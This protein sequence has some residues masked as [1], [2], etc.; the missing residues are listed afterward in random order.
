[1]FSRSLPTDTVKKSL[2]VTLIS[3]FV[4]ICAV[5]LLLATQTGAFTDIAFEAVSALGTAGLTRSYTTSLNTFG[6][7]I[8]MIC[9]YLGRVG[10]ISL[11]IALSGKRREEYLIL[12]EEDIRVG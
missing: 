7:I 4:M 2:T 5:I 8:I 3:V 12:P 1:M 10:P 9:M 6:K 11:V